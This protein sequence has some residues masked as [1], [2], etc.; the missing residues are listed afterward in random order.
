MALAITYIG[1]PATVTIGSGSADAVF[2]SVPIGVA[3]ANRWVL[4]CLWNQGDNNV[5]SGANI[6]GIASTILYDPAVSPHA[7]LWFITKVPNNTTATI[8]VNYPGTQAGTGTVSVYVINGTPNLTR[9]DQGY[10]TGL[11][12]A[13]AGLGV[14]GKAGGVVVE[15]FFNGKAAG[16]PS[17]TWNA[18]SPTMTNDAVNVAFSTTNYMNLRSKAVVTTAA[19]DAGSL[20]GGTATVRI[21]ALSIAEQITVDVATTLTAFSGVTQVAT[22]KESMPST[23][24]TLLKKLTQAAAVTAVES[25]AIAQTLPG[26]TQEID[27]NVVSGMNAAIDQTLRGITQDF[28]AI[29]NHADIAQ[30]LFGITQQI[31]AMMLPSGTIDQTLRAITQAAAVSVAP[32]VD[33]AIDQTLF[34]ITQ[35]FEAR[36]SPHVDTT[37]DMTLFGPLQA[38]NVVEKIP[39][40]IAQTLRGFIQE[41]DGTEAINATASTVLG[42]T[43]GSLDCTFIEYRN[44]GV[45]SGF[46]GSIRTF[47]SVN[48][49]PANTNLTIVVALN[50]GTAGIRLPQSMTIGGVTATRAIRSAT[51]TARCVDIWYASVPAGGVGDVRVIFGDGNNATCAVWAIRGAIDPFVGADA[52]SGNVYGPFMSARAGG[53]GILAV[54]SNGNT[55]PSTP[56]A[57]D[58]LN[59][60]Q[61]VSTT[62]KASG[63]HEALSGG[64]W[65][66][67]GTNQTGLTNWAAAVFMPAV[68]GAFSLTQT[69]NMNASTGSSIAQTLPGLQQLLNV[70]SITARIDQTLRPVTTLFTGNVQL[71]PN[72]IAHLIDTTLPTFI[73][74]IDVHVTPNADIDQTLLGISQEIDVFTIPNVETFIDLTFEGLTQRITIV[75]EIIATIDTVLPFSIQ[76]AAIVEEFI[77]H[78]DQTLNGFSQEIDVNCTNAIIDQTLPGFVQEIDV[79]EE[80]ICFIDQTLLGFTQDFEGFVE[81]PAGVIAGNIIQTLPGF[82]QEIDVSCINAEIAVE[83]QGLTQRATF[84]VGRKHRHERNPHAIPMP[85]KDMPIHKGELEFFRGM[86][87]GRSVDAMVPP[88]FVA[89]HNLTTKHHPNF[90]PPTVPAPRGKPK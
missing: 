54:N 53:V 14:S 2:S 41:I 87:Y 33:T 8:T 90:R 77:C 9:A 22:V 59:V 70:S 29:T 26:I 50:Y 55:T 34:G 72:V 81:E 52:A 6:D 69:L 37:I 84:H 47:P 64:A 61:P 1:T 3:A 28:E 5:P 85:S 11:P 21:S 57:L 83:L 13:Y 60:F 44:T 65:F 88:Q 4:C 66:P 68:G 19:Y 51:A 15:S 63:G 25:S 43:T 35:D 45:D 62:Y 20:T 78:I 36:F 56:A 24:A 86:V 40:T 31:T 79:I 80:M 58:Y 27:I 7:P 49:G 48:F 23:I 17:S 89:K 42:L 82:S 38:L 12:A 67:G 73:Q 18:S 75:E 32:D 74:E 16:S 10:F 39:S 46:G 30:T 76:Q 71:P